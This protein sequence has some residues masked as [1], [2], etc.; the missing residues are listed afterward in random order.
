MKKLVA[1][2]ALLLVALAAPGVASASPSVRYGIQ[3]DAWLSYGPGTL[4]QRLRK[5]DALGVDLVRYTIDWYR[6][7]P[8]KPR[9]A[10]DNRDRAYDWRT[11][12]AVLQGLRRHRIAALVG[13]YGTPAWANGRRSPSHAPTAAADTANFAYAAAKRYSWVRDWLVWNEPNQARWLVPT[14]PATYVSKLLNPAY[15]AIH[16]ANRNAR[17]GGG[18]TAPRGN[19]GLSPVRWIRGMRAARARLDVYAHHPYPLDPR[20]VTPF[21]AGCSHCETIDISELDRLER[22][23]SRNFP[24]KRIWLTEF[25]YQTNP[26][27]R[28]AGVS[29]ALQ[30]L[31]VG[32]AALRVYQSPLIDVLVQYLVQDEPTLA[33]WQSGLQTVSGQAKPALAA[34]VLPIAQPRAAAPTL[35]GQIRPRSGRQPYRIQVQSG[36]AW[37]WLGGT[38]WT[39]SRGYFKRAGLKRGSVVRVWSPRD[40][41]TSGIALRLA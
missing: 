4:E 36:S 33:R 18:V 26:P 31:Y 11:P 17:V 6:V 21:S 13:F 29:P 20:R 37:R 34:F 14:T 2:L 25:G 15:G 10:R 9:N 5:L 24:R 8:A 35:W 27:D 3:D 30:A 39:D 1:L 7:A 38:Y 41:A 40:R 32:Q 28:L 23:V 16:A 19:G 12:D 22:E